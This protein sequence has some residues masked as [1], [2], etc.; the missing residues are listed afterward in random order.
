MV[1]KTQYCIGVMS[2]TS[3]DGVDLAYIKFD[4]SA[5]IKYKI[6]SATTVSYSSLWKEKL[7]NALTS[8]AVEITQ[9]DVD[10]GKYLGKLITSFIKE[11]SITNLDFVASHGHTIFHNPTKGYT[12]QIGDGATI[13]ATCKQKV[14]C[15][16]RTQDVARGGQ[17]APLVPIG[18]KLL[19][20]EYDYCI[21]IGGFANISFEKDN[22]R[23]A[24]DICPANIIL[25]HYT[26]KID[27]EYDDKGHLARTGSTNTS[28]LKALTN[29]SI[30]TNGDSMGN[31]FVVS[32]II[33]L[34]DSFELPIPVI[35]QTVIEHVAQKIGNLLN[36]DA[37]ALITG[38]G[39][40][41]NYLIERIKHHSKAA[42]IIPEKTIIDYKEALIFG[43]LGLLRLINKVNVLASVTG[44]DRDHSSGVINLY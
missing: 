22:S 38:G 30:Y 40:F 7:T 43:L 33:P 44:A 10:Y 35:L 4:S 34:I 12:L 36:T 9:L 37:N 1:N 32:D 39:A 13:A 18:D 23:K 20:S 8:S 19:F 31:E 29:L 27:L 24:F 16:F 42:I 26:R 11:N 15:D 25:N 21:N 2:G 3:L 14:V 5:T 28:L 41:N 6:I 17:G